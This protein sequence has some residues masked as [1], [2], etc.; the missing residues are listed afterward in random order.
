MASSITGVHG[1]PQRL[2]EAAI[3]IHDT[4]FLEAWA[5]IPQC[6]VV[7]EEWIAGPVPPKAPEGI[8]R[9]HYWWWLQRRAPVHA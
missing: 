3:A 5:A 2:R 8:L 4:L 9:R 7:L 1:P 6:K